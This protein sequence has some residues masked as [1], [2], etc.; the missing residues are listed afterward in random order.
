MAQGRHRTVPSLSLGA[1]VQVLRG[2]ANQALPRM[3]F[4]LVPHTGQVP[5]AI[6]RP[7]SLTDTSPSNVRFSLHFTQ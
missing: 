2:R 7:E 4:I 3:R 6:R 5:L 1:V